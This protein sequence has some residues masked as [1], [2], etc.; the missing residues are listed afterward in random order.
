MKA[1]GQR[2]AHRD[3]PYASNRAHKGTL[4]LEGS[5]LQVSGAIV[6]A[7]KVAEDKNGTIL[8][9]ISVKDETVQAEVSVPGLKEA[10]I[11]DLAERPVAQCTVADGKVTLPIGHDQTVALRLVTK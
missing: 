8:R 6:T 3:L 1:L 2:F 11:V 5:F 4:P 10:W 9:L 7:I